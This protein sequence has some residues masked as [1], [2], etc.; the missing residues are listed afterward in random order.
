MTQ[1]YAAPNTGSIQ[2]DASLYRVQ[3]TCHSIHYHLFLLLIGL[4]VQP[5]AVSFKPI[6]HSNL[7][8]RGCSLIQVKSEQVRDW[9]KQK[10]IANNDNN[11]KGLWWGREVTRSFKSW[12]EIPGTGC[13]VIWRQVQSWKW[14][15]SQTMYVLVSKAVRSG[16]GKKNGC[17]ERA[18]VMWL[19]HCAG[20]WPEAWYF[21]WSV[22]W[23]GNSCTVP[24]INIFF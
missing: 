22:A 16:D 2:Q 15:R 23:K 24:K 10:I 12:A 13:S 4:C 7:P 21:G 20:K 11:W 5:T 18:D 6:Y 8:C 17:K 3:A 9:C 14:E 1:W 19:E